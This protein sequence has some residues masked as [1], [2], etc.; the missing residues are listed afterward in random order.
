[1]QMG[2]TFKGAA[3]FITWIENKGETRLGITITK[4]YASA[5]ER[6]RVKRIIREAFRS[7]ASSGLLRSLPIAVDCNIRPRKQGITFAECVQDFQ[8]F[9]ALFAK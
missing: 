8:D 5:V 1:M 9:F 7:I 3:L 2:Q 4:K 6:N